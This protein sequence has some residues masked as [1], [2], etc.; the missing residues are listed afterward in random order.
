MLELFTAFEPFIKQLEVDEGLFDLKK[1]LSELFEILGLSPDLVS[2]DQLLQ[3]IPIFHFFPMNEKEVRVIFISLNHPTLMKFFLE[4][5]SEGL[6][7]KRYIPLVS[8]HSVIFE[9]QGLSFLYLEAKIQL[10]SPFELSL[11]L[12]NYPEYLKKIKLSQLSSVSG[13][14]TRDFIGFSS[15]IKT[16][17]IYEKLMRLTYR[18]TKFLEIDLLEFTKEFLSQLDCLLHFRLEAVFKLIAAAC[19]H[20]STLL[21]IGDQFHLKYKCYLKLVKLESEFQSRFQFKLGA[22]LSVNLSSKYEL[23]DQESFINSVQSRGRG[24]WVEKIQEIIFRDFSDKLFKIF[25]L[26][27][28]FSCDHPFQIL[29]MKEIKSLIQECT[30]Q[31]IKRLTL[32][33]FKPRHEEEIMKDMVMLSK[34]LSHPNDL[35]QAILHFDVHDLGSMT[36][37]L[38]LVRV[39]RKNSED[40]ESILSQLKQ[41][42]NITIERIREIGVIRKRYSKEACTLTITLDPRSFVREDHTIDF[43]RARL[44]IM[45]NLISVFGPFRD[46]EGGMIAKHREAFEEFSK[47]LI[48]NIPLL[49]L[50]NFF[51]SI[52]PAEYRSLVQQTELSYFFQCWWEN[53]HLN[54]SEHTSESGVVY[55]KS[56]SEEKKAKKWADHLQEQNF[57]LHE[58]CWLKMQHQGVYWVGVFCKSRDKKER[59]A[60]S[61]E[62]FHLD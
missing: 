61:H 17:L 27:L 12:E 9:L 1:S 47:E 19:Y 45:D 10:D 43:Q 7:E 52:F 25:Y 24:I 23:F 53:L 14:F 11:I 59:I 4:M 29:N 44:L 36:F 13:S 28:R 2:R 34:Q 38:I 18:F 22:I 33:L 15:E 62:V 16:N 39:K 32:P 50:E 49:V 51:Y 31:S 37:R 56:F 54:Y 41:T 3:L 42:L 35:P 60:I 26:E 30:L 46:F 48:Q 6:I 8:L 58:G 57:K 20:L 55:L 21:E 40:L 5:V